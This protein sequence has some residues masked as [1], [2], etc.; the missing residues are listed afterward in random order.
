M[1]ASPADIYEGEWGTLR[2][3]ATA[4]SDAHW[5]RTYDHEGR[6]VTWR[7]PRRGG[8]I[9][10]DAEGLD[11]PLDPALQRRWGENDQAS[12]LARWTVAETMAK[13]ADIPILAWLHEHGL[14]PQ[15]PR[16][17]SNA[18]GPSGSV[19]LVHVVIAERRTLVTG[20]QLTAHPGY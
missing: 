12:F 1:A 19:R 13:L 9:A 2:W 16:G 6:L 20:G 7:P 3:D 14:P 8:R 18:S 10:V 5:A 11:R 4:A 17:W 15:P